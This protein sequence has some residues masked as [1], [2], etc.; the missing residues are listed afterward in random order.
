MG[1]VHA[2]PGVVPAG[3]GSDP[4]ADVMAALSDLVDLAMRG[5]LQAFAYVTVRGNGN[6]GDGWVG[7]ERGHTHNLAAGISYLS[8]RFMREGPLS[9]PV[10]VAGDPA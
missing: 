5:E 9:H 8:S 6:V 2:L 7:C 4:Q 1:E 10:D 3:S